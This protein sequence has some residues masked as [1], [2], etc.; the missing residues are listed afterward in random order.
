M[1]AVTVNRTLMRTPRCFNRF[2][3]LSARFQGTWSVVRR[4]DG[5]RASVSWSV[6]AQPLLAVVTCMWRCCV[7]LYR[8]LMGAATWKPALV[9]AQA[10]DD[11]MHRF[12]IT[13][14]RELQNTST[15][16]NA[17]DTAELNAR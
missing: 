4:N 11:E 17:Y 8:W 3:E 10:F 2:P 9:Y 13:A 7:S 12:S 6:V 1:Q 16:I 5:L 15:Y 14:T